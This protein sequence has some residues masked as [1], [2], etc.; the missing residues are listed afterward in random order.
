MRRLPAAAAVGALLLVLV[1]PAG[2]VT[3]GEPAEEGEWPWQVA[4]LDGGSVVCGGTLIALDVV[5]TAAHCT[6][7]YD[8][9]DLE[10]TA[11]SI[12]LDGPTRE[13]AVLRQ[14]DGYDTDTTE[15]DI[16]V[17]VLASPF[18]AS[19]LIQ[20]AAVP[21]VATSA[22]VLRAG[23]PTVVTGFGATSEDGGT[24]PV[25]REAE[26][27]VLDDATCARRYA[28]DGD[29]VFAATQVCAGVDRG[30]VDACYGDS[31]GPLVAPADADRSSW[32]LVG[33]VSWG[34]GCGR[35]LRPTVYTEV[36]AY[37][38]WIAEN[39]GLGAGGGM[40]FDVD[41]PL[42][43]P[44]AGATAGKASRYPATV[45]VR[46]FDG[47]VT[48]VAVELHGLSHERPSDLDVW[49]EAPDGTVVT[50]LSDVGGDEPVVAADLRIDADGPE[51]GAGALPLLVKPT[52]REIDDQ[53]KDGQPPA[54]L[55]DLVGADPEGEW[56]LLVADDTDAATGTLEGW[57][58]VL[59]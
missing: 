36:A 51:V 12:D 10:V 50:L 34:A 35:P 11:G 15:N 41:E 49:L 16:S 29:E 39:G 19:S 56:Q 22:S 4:L 43:L 2:A 45:A 20:P 46:G 42:L 6:D 18:E 27:A 3:G 47:P 37:A 13:V 17:L 7:G 58:L 8:A 24:S 40:R 1:R 32:F 30:H 9:G 33:I 54:S 57:T 59:R 26:L 25:L 53:R 21:D 52:D 23:L 48:A 28:E 38:G 14:H 44:A 5:L 55:A 31:G